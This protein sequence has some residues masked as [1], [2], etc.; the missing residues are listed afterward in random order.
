LLSAEG[1][2]QND[3]SE[4]G[5]RVEKALLQAISDQRGQWILSNQHTD[6]HAEYALR[7]VFQNK[8]ISI[9]IDR[10]FIDAQGVRW[11]IDY[12]TGTHSGGGLEQFLNQEAER[13]EPQL[14]KYAQM[15]SELE[16]R[17]TRIALYFP[18]LA[19]WREIK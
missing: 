6:S 9:V 14:K 19:A 3:L 11:I 5:G 4:A 1:V 12:K 7:G 17:P 2:A 13:Y 18:A 15:F 8:L 10:T 16:D